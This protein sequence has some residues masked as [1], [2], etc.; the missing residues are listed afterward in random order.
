MGAEALSLVT[1]ELDVESLDV[2]NEIV[3]PRYLY[4]DSQRFPHDFDFIA[5]LSGLVDLTVVVLSGSR[6]NLRLD[7]ELA[8]ARGILAERAGQLDALMQGVFHAAEGSLANKSG[9]TVLS[10]AVFRLE[11]TSEE[12]CAGTRNEL[13]RSFEAERVR[14][15]R[16]TSQVHAR[17]IDAVRSFLLGYELEVRGQDFSAELKERG[18]SVQLTQIIEG[19]IVVRYDIDDRRSPFA[20]VRKVSDFVGSISLEVGTRR[21][22]LTGS[23]SVESRALD[24]YVI[25]SV[26]LRGNTADISLRKKRDTPDTLSIHLVRGDNGVRAQIVRAEEPA[27][28]FDLDENASAPLA[29]LW[30]ALA[31]SAQVELAARTAVRAVTLDDQDALNARGAEA[32]VQR[33]VEVCRPIVQEVGKRSRSP[34]ELSLKRPLGE[35]RREELFLLRSTLLDRLSVLAAD[36]LARIDSLGLRQNTPA[37][38]LRLFASETASEQRLS[39]P[40]PVPVE[41]IITRE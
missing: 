28:T 5:T 10:D 17:M 3:A 14:I 38:A 9:E 31:A 21:S 35:G 24:E 1:E 40:P 12:L 39:L 20:Q 30:A 13:E 27:S 11:R 25:G 36:D 34:H 19:G 7:D 4:A 16:A 8:H 26:R 29:Q 33:L 41:A 22:W 32:L 6:E 37:P 15:E 23:V 2:T 18:Y